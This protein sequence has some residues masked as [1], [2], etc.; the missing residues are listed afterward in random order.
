MYKRN[1]SFKTMIFFLVLII[2]AGIYMFFYLKNMYY[3]SFKENETSVF[4]DQ[5]STEDSTNESNIINIFGYE[6]N[7]D[8]FKIF[9][10]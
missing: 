7:I 3:D 10:K 9:T 5:N 8:N 4:F 6:I 1:I 2:I